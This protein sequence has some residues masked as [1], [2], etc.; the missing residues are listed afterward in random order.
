MMAFA[1]EWLVDNWRAVLVAGLMF[2][3]MGFAMSANNY[4]ASADRQ[5]S[6]AV[7]AQNL[8]DS[9]QE[10][11]DDMQRRQKSVAALDAKYTKELADA[12]A[13]IDQLK[14]DVTAGKRRLQ[15]NATC[16]NDTSGTASV[17]DAA[18]PRL[19]DSAQRDYFTL[20][21][22]IEV[23]GKKIAGLQEYIIEQCMK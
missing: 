13:T 11:I 19:I 6:L 20:R 1:G 3:C 16:Q 2:L 10:T 9:R 8:A 12:K 21:E 15:L 4:K 18:R 5:K 22:R 23:A 14:H 7:T 17:D